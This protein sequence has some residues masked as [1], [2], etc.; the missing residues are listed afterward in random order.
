MIAGVKKISSNK[1]YSLAILLTIALAIRIFF[2]RFEYAAGWDEINY[3]KLGA[4]GA[5]HG[6]NHVLHPYWSPFYPLAVALFGKIVPDFE[7]AGRLVSVLFG[8]LLI[9]PVY[10]FAVKHFSKKAAW[11]CSLLIAFFPML[12]ESSV[13]A[14]T[15]AL[16]IFAAITGVILGYIAIQKKSIG[17]AAL[18][19]A[20]FCLAYL[21]RPEGIGFLI[22][23]TGLTACVA[24][25]QAIKN[26]E[27]RFILIFLSGIV[28]FIIIGSPYLYYLHGVTGRWT[29]SSK[30][31]ANMQGS[32]TAMENKGKKLNPWLL[33]N[34]DNT[35]LP[36]DDIYH[37]GEFLKRYHQ[38]GDDGASGS[39]VKITPILI[40]KKFVRN[41]SVV[42]T[43]GISQVLGVPILIL[44][45]LGIFGK[46][47]D[48]ERLWRELYLLSYIIFFWFLLIPMFHITERYMLQM[49][50]IVL[51]WS[52]VG[53]ERF[54]E[55]LQQTLLSFKIFWNKRLL[56]ALKIIMVL[57]FAGSFV[58]TGLTRMAIK[59]TNS[60][61]KW[62]EPFEQK[63]AGLW[64]K[65]HCNETP[66]I[67]AWSHAISFYAGN[68]NIKETVT[69][70]Q[71]DLDRVLAYA[72][73]RGAKYLALNEKNKEDFPTINYLMDESQAPANLKLI[74]KDDSIPGLKTL[75]YKI[76]D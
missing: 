4:S 37:T 66:I 51:I 16:Y 24:V 7:L 33:L 15:E 44:M 55:W 8:V 35:Q 48:N 36:D 49:V 40:A 76:L 45:V 17:L 3:L 21:T 70:P 11:F 39:V 67:M 26:H 62:V 64:L 56:S 50:P 61:E 13:S 25:Y 74:Y 28:S 57:I 32:I 5:L 30:G 75:I 73:N 65:E 58:L 43:T 31:A 34:D 19:G 9:V 22:V 41:F 18:T 47:W 20:L 63:Q 10:F 72:R 54:L 71:N 46:P 53:I 60:P 14:L 1:F 68:Y 38:T 69:I 2:L 12:V 29:V 52:G 6:L 42:I 27:F 23:F 59:K